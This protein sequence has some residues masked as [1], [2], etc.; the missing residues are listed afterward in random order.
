MTDGKYCSLALLKQYIIGSRTDPN[1]PTVFN[2]AVSG[3][4]D[5]TLLSDCILQAEATFEQTC[6]SGFD[7]QTYASVQPVLNFV[8]GNGWLHLFARERGP[9][10]AVSAVSFRDIVAG[11]TSWDT[12]SWS[13]SDGIILPNYAVTDTHPLPE[14]WHVMLWP[15]SPLPSRATGQSLVRWSYTGGFAT[16]P[17]SL[18]L[19]IARYAT[20]VYK[21]REAPIGTV[22]NLPLGTMTVPADVPPDI[23]RQMLLWSPVYA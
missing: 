5:D 4:P 10:T 17:S 14:S 7:Q 21:F 16:I 1:N 6:G 2:G 18:A 3:T 9:V 19:L 12:V 11:K 13:A 15:T 8:D 22:T 23:R 20:Y